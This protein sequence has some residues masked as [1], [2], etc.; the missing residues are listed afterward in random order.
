[1]I[2][3]ALLLAAVPIVTTPMPAPKVV[4]PAQPMASPTVPSISVHRF[5][6]LFPHGVDTVSAEQVEGARRVSAPAICTGYADTTGPEDLNVA[7]SLRRAEAVA[8][9]IGCVPVAGG[10]TT[11]FGEDGYN[12]RVTVLHDAAQTKNK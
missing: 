2:I 9:K 6:V 8:A 12:R 4:G 10:E 1:M 7:L 3:A 5:D 11:M